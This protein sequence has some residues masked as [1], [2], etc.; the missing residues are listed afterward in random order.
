MEAD[1]RTSCQRESE[2]DKRPLHSHVFFSTANIS[3]TLLE[4]FRPESHCETNSLDQ[5]F[6]RQNIHPKMTPIYGS[7]VLSVT[8]NAYYKL[9]NR[10]KA[11]IP[12]S[13]AMPQFVIQE[14]ADRASILMG[15]PTDYCLNTN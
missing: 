4:S 11:F 9:L 10:L 6:D 12:H 7:K 2:P 14:G 8:P 5:L 3:L 15:N 13:K 1:A